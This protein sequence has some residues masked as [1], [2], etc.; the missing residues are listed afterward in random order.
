[1]CACVRVCGIKVDHEYKVVGIN[2]L[3]MKSISGQKCR[4]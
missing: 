3:R 4:F 1:V 2:W